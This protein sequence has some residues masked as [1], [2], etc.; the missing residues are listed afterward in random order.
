MSGALQLPPDWCEELDDSL[1]AD[2]A[3]Q[4]LQR[5]RQ[6]DAALAAVRTDPAALADARAMLLAGKPVA[7][8]STLSLR[9]CGPGRLLMATDSARAVV[10]LLIELSRD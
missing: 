1:V 2:W 6:L 3:V 5:L 10:A 7:H 4:A 9:D 8:T